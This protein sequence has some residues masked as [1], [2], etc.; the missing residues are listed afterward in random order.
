MGLSLLAFWHFSVEN[1]IIKYHHLFILV[2]TSLSYTCIFSV[3]LMCIWGKDNYDVEKY[4]VTSVL[5]I[6]FLKIV[7]VHESMFQCFKTGG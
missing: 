6:Y 7:K 2:Q 5:R 1:K 4:L 3:K